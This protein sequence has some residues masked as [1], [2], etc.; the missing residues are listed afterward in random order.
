M[1]GF[2]GI[3]GGFGHLT[4]IRAFIHTMS[5]EKPYVIITTNVHA[6]QLFG[7]N[8][9]AFID[10][11]KVPDK[12]SLRAEIKKTLTD[13]NVN[14]LYVDAFPCGILGELDKDACGSIEINYLARRLIWK[15]YQQ[16]I[17]DRPSFHKA[18]VFEPLENEH[19]QF[20][21]DHFS[22]II[23]ADLQYPEPEGLVSIEKKI[24]GFKKPIWL[25]VHS[26]HSE[27][28]EV[29]I[30]HAI[31]LATI[32]RKDPQFVILSDQEIALPGGFVSLQNE[33]PVQWYPYAEKI[34]T[35]AGFNTWYQ[36]EKYRDKHECIPFKRKFDDQF[37][38]VKLVPAN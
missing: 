21:K 15:N 22:E 26:T 1:T 3:G 13:Y 18:Y 36:L 19:L 16:L 27:E 35:A 6:F 7:T 25:I 38:R 20:L 33:N 37:W 9:I 17:E 23:L 29:L 11:Q 14:Q 32:E 4:R 10:P 31:D 28:L 8:A 12:C 24:R 30:N 2:Y 5:V 34:L